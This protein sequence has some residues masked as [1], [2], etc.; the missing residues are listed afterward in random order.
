MSKYSKK[1][2]LHLKKAL[3]QPNDNMEVSYVGIKLC[4]IGKKYSSNVECQ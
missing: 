4:G 3:N 2:L 1:M